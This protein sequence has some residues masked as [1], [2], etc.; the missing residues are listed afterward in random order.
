VKAPEHFT[1]HF[2]TEATTTKRVGEPIISETDMYVV[3]YQLYGPIYGNRMEYASSRKLRD[4]TETSTPRGLPTNGA[5]RSTP[6]FIMQST[7][8]I[9]KQV[10]QRDG[11]GGCSLLKLRP[12]MPSGSI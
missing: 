6:R 4:T 11:K 10:S 3:L 9:S 7:R 2:I 8:P 1:L 12:R 5:R